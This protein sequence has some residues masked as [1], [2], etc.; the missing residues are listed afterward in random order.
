MGGSRLSRKTATPGARSI[1]GAALPAVIAAGVFVHAVAVIAGLA[2]IDHAIS[3]GGR[4]AGT[5]A[6]ARLGV[7]VRS[8]RVAT[9][10]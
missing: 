4:L 3:A 5:T 1:P 10:P 8:A 2:G 6:G 7:A 9:F